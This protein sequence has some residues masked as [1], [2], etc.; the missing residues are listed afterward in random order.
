MIPY[1]LT[2]RM[3]SKRHPHNECD[4]CCAYVDKK[5]G[6]SKARQRKREEL[7][8]AEINYFKEITDEKKC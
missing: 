1:G 2:K 4:I 6:R 7:R 3:S 5:D 8:K